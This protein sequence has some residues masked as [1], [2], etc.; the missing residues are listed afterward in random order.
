MK[1]LLLFHFLCV[2]TPYTKLTFFFKVENTTYSRRLRA[3]PGSIV[4]ILGPKWE[5]FWGSYE[6]PKTVLF[7]AKKHFLVVKNRVLGKTPLKKTFSQK[8]IFSP[9]KFWS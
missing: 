9:Q 4:R 1:I 5:Y 8:N 3:R 2:G 6:V 7:F